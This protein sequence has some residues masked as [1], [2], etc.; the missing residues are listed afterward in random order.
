MQP[1]LKEMIS[2]RF[3]DIGIHGKWKMFEDALE[4]YDINIDEWD[5]QGK[6]KNSSDQ[7]KP[8]W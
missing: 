5:E 3:V 7:L 6:P 2:E 4:E 8:L 1:T